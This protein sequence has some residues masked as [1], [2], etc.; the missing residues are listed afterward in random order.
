M[1]LPVTNMRARKQL[2]DLLAHT[3]P[4][5]GPWILMCQEVYVD[6]KGGRITQA[7]L[8]QAVREADNSKLSQPS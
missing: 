1:N 8:E 6:V 4:Q 2:V 5:E 7:E 3:G